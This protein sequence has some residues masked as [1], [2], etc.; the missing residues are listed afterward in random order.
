MRRLLLGLLATC[1]PVVLAAQIPGP[2]VNMVSG[3]TFPGGDPWLQKQNE[4]SIAV[5]TRNPCTLLGGANDYRA[6]YLPGLPD[7]KEIGDAWVGLYKSKNC[8]QTWFSDLMPGY[9]QDNSAAGNAS[10]VKGLSTG[11][12]PVVRAGDSGFFGYSF[13]AFNRG[14]STGKLAFARFID[15][16]NRERADSIG[17]GGT[18]IVDNGS[19]G[20]FLDKPWMIISQ[21]T[22]TCTVDGETIPASTIH[23]VWTV[24]VGNTDQV[25][26]TKLYYSKST[27]C[28]ASFGPATKLSEGYPINQG[29]VVASDATA[30]NIYVLWRQLPTEK[31]TSTIFMSKSLDGGN[32]FSK[33]ES[34]PYFT[35]FAAFDQGTTSKTFR[36]NAYASAIVDH[37]GRLHVVLSVR[38]F[39]PNT[40]QARVI[41]SSYT[42]AGGWTL[43]F[44]VD[45]ETYNGHQ[46]MPALTYAGGK[47]QVIWYDL[48][49]TEAAKASLGAYETYIREI[50][51]IRHTLDLRGAEGTIAQNGA[52]S[53]HQYG[54]LQLPV[55][56]APRISQYLLGSIGYGLAQL[57]FN[58][59]N[60]KL[61]AGG[62]VPFIGDY[63]DVAGLRSIPVRTANGQQWVLNDGTVPG[64]NTGTFHAVWTDNRDAHVPA[65]V[66]EPSA[67]GQSGPTLG[68]AAPGTNACVPNS[69]SALLAKT[70]NANV[71]TSR[72]T[73]GLFVAAPGNAKPITCASC[74][75][76]RI[77]RAFG[78]F[79]Y[80]TTGSLRTFR[81]TIA[82]QPAGG[83]ASFAQFA[84]L[85][86]IDVIIPGKSSVART[87]YITSSE[88]YPAIVVNVVEQNPPPNTTPLSAAVLLNPDVANP[89]VANPDVANPD[90]ANNEVHNPDVANPDVANPDVANPDVANPDVANPDVA[91]PDVANPD[92]ANPDVANP[93]VANPDVAN[94]DVANATLQ[95]GSVTDVSFDVTNAGNTTSTYQAKVSVSGNTNP[96][97]FQ[98]I[99]R[100]VYKTPTAENCVLTEAA[101][102]Q[103]LFNITNP[104]VL[105][106]GFLGV[107]DSSV[108]NATLLLQP[109]E[110]VK[111]T[112][113]VFD[114]DVLSTPVSGQDGVI[115]P[116]CALID[117]SIGCSIATNS[118]L[119]TVQAQA[120]NNYNGVIDAAPQVDAVSSQPLAM[121]TLSLPGGFVNQPF[122]PEVVQAQGGAAPFTW[123]VISGSL[124]PGLTL[125]ASTGSVSGMPTT[126][127]DYTYTLQVQDS[128][129]AVA[130]GP[131]AS[132]IMLLQPGDVFVADGLPSTTTGNVYR[133]TSDGSVTELIAAISGRPISI[134]KDEQ[135]RLI[136]LDNTNDRILRVTPNHVKTLFSGSPLSN[137][138]AI[139]RD[140]AGNIIVGDNVTD[141][142]YKLAPD[143]SS[144]S[145]LATLPSSPSEAQDIE[146]VLD[147]TDDLVVTDDGGSTVTMLR[148][149][150]SGSVT[151]ILNETAVIQRAGGLVVLGDGNY[152]LG[153]FQQSRISIVSPAGTIVGHVT[154][155][156]A[157]G[158]S[159]RGMSL[160]LDGNYI[161][162]G[163]VSVRR[164]TPAGADTVI[165][166]GSPFTWVSDV[167]VNRAEITFEMLPDG[168]LACNGCSLTNEFANLGVVF[169]FTPI[170]PAGTTDTT[171]SGPSGADR[172]S[173]PG[174]H[175][176]TAPTVPPAQGGGYWSGIMRMTLASNPGMVV[177]QLRGNDSI[178]NPFGV[179]ALD[180]NGNAIT[181][182]TRQN[183]FTYT[184]L[185][186]FTSREEIVVV[187]SP[188]GVAS[189]DLNMNVGLLFV[190][191][192]ILKQ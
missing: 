182:I 169:S 53:F 180:G 39:V 116:F 25:V 109:G 19:S 121:A 17:Y 14:T 156:G 46:I 145:E 67:D 178:G 57:Q 115:T 133:L 92:V 123:S 42:E 96:F 33:A 102:N 172:S 137:P 163:D 129:G 97:I 131:F 132:R 59:A 141:K 88:K 122:G 120:A 51:P 108:Q 40:T 49:E 100:R 81:M 44:A 63:I 76:G 34:V 68:Y 189:V 3:K 7:D 117:P 47:L 101:Q 4:P 87:V 140:A 154:L 168:T 153:D 175:S 16:N 126:A 64:G 173:E 125:N 20:Q 148:I 118:V 104:V 32:T 89:D 91:N 150:P 80:N 13:I 73:P 43:P 166:T 181:N 48:R 103:I 24:F 161:T 8:G 183:V 26:R 124:P 190:D 144:I 142:I 187:Q 113:R 165:K 66:A 65:S 143:G 138:V 9:P 45:G 12:D 147:P 188:N 130:S 72:I 85:T 31:T 151:T 99:G 74:L 69:P 70:R 111:V 52:V 71:Y 159:I 94:P 191:R 38:G 98:L 58:M 62:T 107:N 134:D 176:V 29:A 139:A 35:S 174:N 192:L 2:N 84:T 50:W 114:K 106:G 15:H 37:A 1:V 60:L 10:P 75:G 146:I 22:G 152:A 41:Y 11:A 93:D 164:I 82:N 23:M 167:L 149:S 110:T 6:V 160:D 127:G 95:N 128:L 56:S 135:G 162:G 170:L 78:V 184:G 112:L 136:V 54:I 83:V 36:T 157:A 21:G 155:T 18:T 28:G 171:L 79:A 177:F 30:T 185:G 61:Y 55:N 5:S 90:V 27:N 158:A 105:P 119:L 77:Q 86:Q 179:T 186:A